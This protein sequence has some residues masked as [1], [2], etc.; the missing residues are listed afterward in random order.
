MIMEIMPDLHCKD[1]IRKE[2]KVLRSRITQED[3]LL[4]SSRIM[5]SF[6]GLEKL[7][8]PCLIMCYMNFKNEVNTGA[9]IK[10]CLAQG[11]GIA[12]PRVESV[13]DGRI[14][15]PYRICNIDKDVECG[16]YGIMEPVT[17]TARRVEPQEIDLVIV[18]GLAFGLNRQRIGYGAGYYDR[19]LKEV[20]KDCV[21]IG[22]AYEIQILEKIYENKLDVPMDIIITEERII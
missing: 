15:V 22:F 2:M 10:K 16:S 11:K 6:F 7:S 20:R 13:N 14:I 9:L 21:K 3:A 4:K 12:L 5:E 18:P 1:E 17:D 19:L 8:S